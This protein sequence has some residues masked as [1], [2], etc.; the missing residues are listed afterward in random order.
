MGMK[1]VWVEEQDPISFDLY[2]TMW[3]T[4]IYLDVRSQWNTADRGAEVRRQ[5]F[6]LG[7]YWGHWPDLAEQAAGPESLAKHCSELI[8]GYEKQWRSRKQSPQCEF[9]FDI[10][11][12]SSNWVEAFVRAWRAVRPLKVT[13]WTFESWQ[14]GRYTWMNKSLV[15]LVNSDVNLTVVPQLYNGQMSRVNDSCAVA[16][17]LRDMIHPTGERGG[18]D[19][20]RIRFF[21]DAAKPI[22]DG[23]NGYLFTNRRLVG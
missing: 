4:H 2:K 8:A 15:D 21:Y 20:A 17:E 11:W 14:G 19:E 23:W 22:P 10:E 3:L 9:Q 12:H 7:L 6:T 5:G 16:Q 1:A 13:S 18:V